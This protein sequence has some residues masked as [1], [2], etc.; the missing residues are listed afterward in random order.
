MLAVGPKNVGDIA[1]HL[2]LGPAA[3]QEML[4]EHVAFGL[5]IEEAGLY[6]LNIHA[7]LN[8]L[9]SMWPKL[10]WQEELLARGEWDCR[11]CLVAGD[12]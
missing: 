8:L 10:R 11:T 4:D 7:V 12:R 3:A 2:C 1:R 5:V 6:S 9:T